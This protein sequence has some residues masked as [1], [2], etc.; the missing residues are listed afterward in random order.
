MASGNSRQHVP[1][2]NLTSKVKSV[3]DVGIKRQQAA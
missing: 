2:S 3:S 1:S